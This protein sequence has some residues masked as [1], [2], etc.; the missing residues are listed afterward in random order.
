MAAGPV[1]PQVVVAAIVL[2]LLVVLT[3]V[4]LPQALDAQSASLQAGIVGNLTLSPPGTPPELS[5]SLTNEGN[6]GQPSPTFAVTI[7]D[8]GGTLFPVGPVGLL[9][10]PSGGGG[11]LSVPLAQN[12]TGCNLN[13][14]LDRSQG[15]VQPVGYLRTFGSTLISTVFAVDGVPSTGLGLLLAQN[16]TNLFAVVPKGPG[17]TNFTLDYDS[18]FS[19]WNYSVVAQSTPFELVPGTNASLTLQITPAG[20]YSAFV[21]GVLELSGYYRGF[22]PEGGPVALWPTS[23]LGSFLGIYSSVNGQTGSLDLNGTC[24][25]LEA[26]LVMTYSAPR[27]LSSAPGVAFAAAPADVPGENDLFAVELLISSA[28]QVSSATVGPCSSV[29]LAAGGSLQWSAPIEVS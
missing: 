21:D 18:Y 28:A 3:D 22:V 6:A 10:G 20:N 9:G 1:R 16:F 29:V 11:D 27:L 15:D 24:E 26:A 5:A 14:S 8:L 13:L 25:E 7:L 23:A 17:S 12:T 4:S 2:A 19:F